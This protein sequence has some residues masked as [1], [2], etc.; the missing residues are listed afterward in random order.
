MTNRH[1]LRWTCLLAALLLGWVSGA[2]AGEADAPEVSVRQEIRDTLRVA[3]R[4]FMGGRYEQAQALYAGLLA[5]SDFGPLI[6]YDVATKADFARIDMD[7][8]PTRTNNAEGERAAERHKALYNERRTLR[9]RQREEAYYFL[10][11]CRLEEA[12]A[13]DGPFDEAIRDLLR[14]GR[15]EFRFDRPE[16]AR[17]ALFWAARAQGFAGRHAAAIETYREIVGLGGNPEMEGEVAW[18]LVKSLRSRIEELQATAGVGDARA[19]EAIGRL[20]TVAI[21]TLLRIVTTLPD[22]PFAGD[23]Q[24]LLMKMRFEAGQHE[25]SAETAERLSKELSGDDPEFAGAQAILGQIAMAK[26]DVAEAVSFFDQ[27]ASAPG[28]PPETRISAQL[29]LG[30]CH[31]LLAQ[32]AAAEGREAHLRKARTALRVAVE[33]MPRE[34]TER[35]SAL[36]ALGDVLVRLGE[37]EDAVVYLDQIANRKEVRTEARYL[38]G[39]A[40]RGLGKFPQAVHDFESVLADAESG[41]SRTFL[42]RVLAGLAQLESDRGQFGAALIHYHAARERARAQWDFPVVA[43][44]DIGIAWSRLHL[45]RKQEKRQMQAEERAA[46]AL[47]S[48]L[49]IRPDGDPNDSRHALR[50]SLLR[51]Q[52]VELESRAGP[53]NCEKAIAIVNELRQRDADRVRG[54]KLDFI[55]GQALAIMAGEKA[56]SA[57]EQRWLDAYAVRTVSE[58]YLKTTEVLSNAVQSNPRGAYAAETNYVLA[59]THRVWA[60][61]LLTVAERHEREERTVQAQS[62]RQDGKQQLHKSAA[63]YARAAALAPIGSE[64]RSQARMQLGLTYL[65][66]EES[67]RARDAFQVLADNPDL[68]EAIRRTATRLWALA[69]DR[70]GSWEEALAKLQPQVR[71][72]LHSA[73]QAGRLLERIEQPRKAY[74]TYRAGLLEAHD[75]RSGA[76]RK[77]AAELLYRRYALG[78]AHAED[79]TVAD[80]VR[81]MREDAEAGLRRVME[82]H[83]DTDWAT[84]AMLSLGRYLLQ[85]GRVDEAKALAEW[86]RKSADENDEILRA[87]YLIGG[88]ARRDEEEFEIFRRWLMQAVP[89]TRAEAAADWADQVDP[90]QLDLGASLTANVSDLIAAE[91]LRSIADAARVEG[92]ADLALDLYAKVYAQYPQIAAEADRARIGAA[93]IHAARGG[94]EAL[95]IAVRILEQGHDAGRMQAVMER[96]QSR[97]PRIP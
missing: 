23:A 74:E 80:G 88:R 91:A 2:W 32:T 17:A 20:R 70:S 50:R 62:E 38:R 52:A 37:Y 18:H 30:R 97:G 78:L 96:L 39:I 24:V 41:E 10:A 55:E 15:N 44:S 68:P 77:L 72:D 21:E 90:L 27:A 45:G 47:V 57:L 89:K 4:Y 22:S 81:E 65:A 75:A 95:E 76:D 11:R 67:D 66:L 61:F 84:L 79:L 58:A 40:Q 26:G 9:Q 6:P 56:R 5:R 31:A 48:L 85:N 54:D 43:E 63:P 73:V 7:P 25:D 14:V 71:V 13:Q 92:Q 83:T 94:E 42:M 29:D 34:S 36:L 69:L 19:N 87:S 8:R 59:E 33:A 49:A 35:P 3:R 28:C 53:A 1:S 12:R 82:K 51:F 46:S 64:M 16:H 60:R 93:E 86:G